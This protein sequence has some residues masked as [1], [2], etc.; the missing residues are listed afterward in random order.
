MMAQPMYAPMASPYPVMQPVKAAPAP[1]PAPVATVAP[2]IA[3]D[4]NAS[5][6]GSVVSAN[7]S[8][9]SAQPSYS[10]FSAHSQMSNV[11]NLSNMSNMSNMSNVSRVSHISAGGTR[12]MQPRHQAT[13]LADTKLGAQQVN[14]KSIAGSRIAHDASNQARVAQQM[15]A[16][17]RSNL[18][19]GRNAPIQ[20]NAGRFQPT[21]VR[22][23]PGVSQ[24]KRWK[25]AKTEEG[26]FYA[27]HGLGHW[28]TRTSS[29]TGRSY[30]GFKWG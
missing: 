7:Y 2:T 23:G 21:P 15:A 14:Q 5:V 18:A 17:A 26:R 4:D 11:S 16:Q 1:T 24:Y 3:V 9:F 6:G 25:Q 27:H 20:R 29:T 19:A 28:E 12:T 30:Y 8:N 10:N 13:R 22:R